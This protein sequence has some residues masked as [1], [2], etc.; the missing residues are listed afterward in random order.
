MCPVIGRRW[1]VGV[2]RMA[3]WLALVWL[4]AGCAQTPTPIFISEVE[5]TQTAL[6]PA[7]GTAPA[8]RLQI[9]MVGA[10]DGFQEVRAALSFEPLLG[11]GMAGDLRPLLAAELPEASPDGLSWSIQLRD[12]VTFQDGS[13][14]DTAQV[15]S[16][17]QALLAQ[18][19]DDRPLA[20]IAFQAL[21]E[22]IEPSDRGVVIT[23][24]QPFEDFP[25]L[26]ADPA[27]AIVSPSG[28]GTGPFIQTGTTE[29]GAAFDA[30]AGYHGG[31]PVLPGIDVV[32]TDVSTLQAALAAG[33]A[34]PDLVL[35]A[36]AASLGEWYRPW[37]ERVVRRSLLLRGQ[38]GPL[39]GAGVMDALAAT[40]L[41]GAREGLAAAG[42]PDGFD[43]QVW[44]TG[45]AEALGG[46]LPVSLG[47]LP[48]GLG[49]Q[50][51]PDPV[52]ARTLLDPA[53][54]GF[55]G[56]DVAWSAPWERGWW[57]WASGG[58]IMQEQA[59]AQAVPAA[60]RS[61]LAGLEM[62]GDGWP[63]ITAATALLP[64]L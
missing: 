64:S 44:A 40:D 19:G 54:A 11:Y 48:I 21:V 10:E 22:R 53:G 39:A 42:L 62:T 47:D 52:L 58:V 56:I 8:D 49:I 17:L 16:A 14:C 27:L 1:H 5:A 37:P 25:G 18:D 32:S 45:R 3:G 20:V 36:E 13:P 12:G 15:A 46:D 55:A 34:V 24:K 61:G 2:W 59:V 33:N 38:V 35:G 7:T 26:L 30:F 41:V 50:I 51:V 43:I 23:L 60:P 29:M 57:A 9:W 63:R 28:M 31:V 4:L 6:P